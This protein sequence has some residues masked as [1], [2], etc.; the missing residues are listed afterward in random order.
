MGLNDDLRRLSEAWRGG[1]CLAL[2]FDFDGTLAPLVTHPDLA[3]CPPQMQDVLSSLAGLPRTIVGIISGRTLADLKSKIHLPRLIF[4][5]T[6]GLEM[7]FHSRAVRHAGAQRRA[8]IVRAA[9]ESI[10]AMVE[11]FR[12]AWIEH[13]PLALTVHYRHVDRQDVPLLKQSLEGALAPFHGILTSVDGSK[14]LEIL[15]D[16]GWGKGSALETIVSQDGR[17]AVPLY[18]GN[19]ANDRG[20]LQAAMKLGGVAI[21]VG[22]SA[23]DHAMHRLES[24]EDLISALQTLCRLLT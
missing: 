22:S 3:V 16:V 21:G 6:C 14:A 18:A 17:N 4:A 20:A 12:G 23:P 24:V 5:G 13:K 9:A 2:L 1:R 19:D 11:S 7:E 8:P 10:G 15:P